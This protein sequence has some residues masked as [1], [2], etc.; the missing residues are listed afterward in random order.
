VAPGEILTLFGFQLG[1][2]LPAGVTL[3]AQRRVAAESGGVRVFFDNTA[4]PILYASSGQVTVVVPFDVAGKPS[5][6]VTLERDGRR[7]NTLVVGVAGAAPG[8]FTANATGQGPGAFLNEDGTLNS[9]ANPA[10]AGSTVV[11]YATGLG[12]MVPNMADGELAA[13]P[14]PRPANPFT[15]RIG[16][17]VAS[18]TYGGS[19][20]GLVAGLVQLN[21]IVPP[22][23]APG[24]VPVSIEAAGARSGRNVSLAIR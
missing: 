6:R 2:D 9:A 22:D 18:V 8:F 11:L 24:I 12:T 17:R 13:P 7:T 19:A 1:P 10:A 20:P 14:Y 21:V 4:A 15:V 16:D 3:T 23:L 5:V